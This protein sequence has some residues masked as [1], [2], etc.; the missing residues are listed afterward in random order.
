MLF[1]LKQKVADPPN[2]AVCSS[3]VP[4]LHIPNPYGVSSYNVTF[5]LFFA[6]EL[7]TT[8]NS[9]TTAVEYFYWKIKKLTFLFQKARERPP[10]C[11]PWL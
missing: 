3:V 8:H 6:F 5:F 2:I 1:F 9:V 10:F 11:F 4:V 7:Q